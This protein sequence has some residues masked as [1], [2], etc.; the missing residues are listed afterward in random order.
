MRNA[1]RTP[2]GAAVL[3]YVSAA[4]SPVIAQGSTKCTVLTATEIEQITKR[5][6]PA[7]IPPMIAAASEVPKGVSE[8]DY[9]GISFSLTAQ[10]SKQWFDATRTDQAKRG[11]KVTPV[12]G[13]GDDAYY[14]YLPAKSLGQM[15]IASGVGQS[16]LV[17][18]DR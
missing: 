1:I 13:V 8:C 2:L 7:N 4:L 3:F 15:G 9:L 16:R 11:T 5:P 14:W 6:N 12:S 18:M 10:M 17:M